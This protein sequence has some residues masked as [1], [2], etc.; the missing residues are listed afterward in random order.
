[1]VFNQEVTLFS[2]P[3]LLTSLLSPLSV[4]AWWDRYPRDLGQSLA[5]VLSQSTLSVPSLYLFLFISI[6]FLGDIFHSRSHYLRYTS[7]IAD[8]STLTVSRRFLIGG[9]IHFTNT[10]TLML[11]KEYPFCLVV[12]VML[13]LRIHRDVFDLGTTMAL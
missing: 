11:S 13:I 1:M 10:V 8:A 7:L 2:S 12:I 4:I 5:R 3:L 9:K 6:L